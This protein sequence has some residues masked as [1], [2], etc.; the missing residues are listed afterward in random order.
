MAAGEIGMNGVNVP[1][2]VVEASLC[3]VV[4]VIIRYRKMVAHFVLE[5]E[6]AIKFV[7]NKLVL[8]M[9]QVSEHNN[10]QSSI[11]KRIEEKRT[12]GCHISIVV[13]RFMI[14]KTSELL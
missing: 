4:N 1:V 14:T 10:V 5:K 8:K 6:F 9:S 11:M 13:S 3:K 7:I 12:I 2:L